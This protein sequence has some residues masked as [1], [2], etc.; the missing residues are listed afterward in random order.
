MST[1][2]KISTSSGFSVTCMAEYVMAFTSV[3]CSCVSNENV[4][5]RL[6][7]ASVAVCQSALRVPSAAHVAGA[8]ME[9]D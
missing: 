7:R 9:R 5:P 8:V 2:T 4:S 3:P 1:M 6:C